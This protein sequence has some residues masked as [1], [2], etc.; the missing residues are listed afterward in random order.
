M[1]RLL[2]IARHEF[3]RHVRR[4]G[5]VI[6]TVAVPLIGMIVTLVLGAINRNADPTAALPGQF[7][8][9]IGY[10]DQAGILNTVPEYF[11]PNLFRAFPDEAAA[12]AA[13]SSDAI[14]SYYLLPADYLQSGAVTRVA[15]QV[16]LSSDETQIFEQLI[17]ANLLQGSDPRLIQRLNEPLMVQTTRLDASGQPAQDRRL[18][19]ATE[20]SPLAFLVPYVFAMLLYF[21]IIFASGLM[22]QSV[23]EEKE[24]RT[25]ELIVTSV[26]PWQ[27]LSGKALG[28]GA[29]GLIQTLVWLISGRF[30]LSFSTTQLALPGN[31]TLPLSVWVLALV[32]FL[33]GYMVYAS[34]FAGIGATITNTREGSQ[35]TLLFVIPFIIPLW[36]L[37]AIIQNPNGLLAT[38]LSIIPLT[39]PVTMMIRVPLTDVSGWQVALSIALLS[40]TVVL[41]I[42]GAARLFRVTTLLAGKKLAPAEIM[43]AL[44]ASGS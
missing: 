39:A 11:P 8:G 22:M 21:T 19:S 6:L 18:D 31:F 7:S 13:L 25:I 42:W 1:N 26:K 24:N 43:R 33:L 40:G 5:F 35:L 38:V 20:Q 9:T 28:L 30:L 34:L 17:V 32:Y 44:R 27:L 36:F 12:Q 2:L 37:G 23:V 14:Q 16:Q 4:P 29:L 15:Q 41:C 10:V 3:L